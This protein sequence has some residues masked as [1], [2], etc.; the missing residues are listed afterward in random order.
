MISWESP[1]LYREQIPAFV[2]LPAQK[3]AAQ[4]QA[5]RAELAACCQLANTAHRRCLPPPELHSLESLH[6][7]P[8]AL[9]LLLAA[10]SSA[11]RPVPPPAQP[12]CNHSCTPPPLPQHAPQNSLPSP[13]IAP[14][15]FTCLTSSPCHRQPAPIRL[16]RRDC[17]R[18]ASCAPHAQAAAAVESTQMCPATTLPAVATA[19]RC[20]CCAGPRDAPFVV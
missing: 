3:Q 1:V 5:A 15:T 20:A 11:L 8:P 13:S 6:R 4:K 2:A 16:S 14:S 9:L 19:V 18:S 7:I 10:P 12:R 17:H